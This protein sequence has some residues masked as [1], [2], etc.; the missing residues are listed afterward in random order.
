[1]VS[2]GGG[3]LP[4]ALQP[5]VALGSSSVTVAGSWHSEFCSEVEKLGEGLV[6]WLLVPA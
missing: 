2:A 6:F 4:R 5:A 1:M 3:L